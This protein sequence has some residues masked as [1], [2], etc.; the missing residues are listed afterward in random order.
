MGSLGGPHGMQ[1][2]NSFSG[3]RGEE[4]GAVRVGSGGGLRL[5]LQ[6]FAFSH[7]TT[8]NRKLPGFSRFGQF[9]QIGHIPGGGGGHFCGRV[10]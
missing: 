9:T 3:P 6:P 1:T 2:P 5:A 4:E 10:A 8:K 7:S